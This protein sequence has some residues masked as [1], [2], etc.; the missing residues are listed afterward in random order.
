MIAL[1][2]IVPASGSGPGAGSSSERRRSSKYAVKAPGSGVGDFVCAE[3]CVV[4]G[5]RSGVGSS[6]LD[7]LEVWRLIPSAG[8]ARPGCKPCDAA[9]GTG[10]G[11]L[12]LGA[13]TKSEGLRTRGSRSSRVMSRS[14]SSVLMVSTVLSLA[15]LFRLSTAGLHTPL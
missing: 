5:V 7:E 15:C 6:L 1:G 13:G 11:L 4:A 12:L 3:V 14:L 9:E 2:S 10:R 8:R